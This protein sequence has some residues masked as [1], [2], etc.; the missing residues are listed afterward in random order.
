MMRMKKGNGTS[1]MILA[2]ACLTFLFVNVAAAKQYVVK[3]TADAGSHTL[4][5]A[6][7]Q[8]NASPGADV[9][10]FDI[11]GTGP[12]TIV[13]ASPLPPLTDEA[14][15]IIDGLS[16]PGSSA[17]SRPPGTLTLHILL[18]GIHAGSTAGIWI[19]S[20]NNLVQGLV[21]TRFTED[22]I[23]MQAAP[24][25]SSGNVVRYCIIGL[26]PKGTESRGNGIEQKSGRWAG[27]SLISMK[28]AP[29]DLSGNTIEKNVI[30]G[31]RGDGIILADCPG[32][33]VFSNTISGNFI[34]SSRAGDVTRGNERDGILIS[35]GCHGNTVT[36]NVITG[37]GSDGIHLAGDMSRSAFTYQNAITRNRIGVSPRNRLLG[38]EVNGVNVGGAEYGLS[39]G[40]A[41]KNRI[42]SNIIAGNKRNGIVVWEHESSASNA[43]QNHI[44]Q[45]SIFANGRFPIDLGNDGMTLNDAADEDIGPNEGMNAPVIVSADFNRGVT[46]VRGTVSADGDPAT[47]SVELYKYIDE[48]QSDVSE[49]LYLGRVSP[50][51]GGNWV[52]ST[53]GL[54]LPEDRVVAQSTDSHD[55]SSEYSRERKVVEGG[56]ALVEDLNPSMTR[57]VELKASAVIAETTTDENNGAVMFTV[58]VE[59][60]CWGILE[61]FTSRGELVRTLVNR[62]LPAGDYAIE[63][64]G[65]NWKGDQVEPGTYMCR[66][67]ADGVRQS[68][69]IAL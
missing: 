53:T 44:G 13:P 12:H 30:S 36:E 23:R 7:L 48:A 56:R 61:I 49:S 14:G 45:N 52:Y 40:F 39:G 9:I 29:G 17:G 60:P 54:L 46:T 62:W 5:W 8:A 64:D 47:I 4:R 16:Q 25:G 18:D 42:T 33:N 2:A 3:S 22:G 69:N 6:I 20:S 50:D 24:E 37:N 65:K 38:N 51:G 1:R 35:G 28:H 27:L 32:G 41:V 21:I 19:L 59:H 43:D 57:S 26:D 34:G 68:T 63:W 15:V 31:N 67:D 55:N 66:F 10:T 11:P 58:S